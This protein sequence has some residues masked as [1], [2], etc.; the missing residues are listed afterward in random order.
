MSQTIR[1]LGI[2]PALCNTGL[3]IVDYHIATGELKVFRIEIAQTE[4]SADG[5]VV[6]K[7]SDDLSRGRIIVRE[8]QRVIA[9]Y[10]PSLAVAEVP[11]GCQSAR[12][13]FSNGV[14]C[15][16]LASITIPM[17][18]VSPTEVKLAAVGDKNASKAKMIEW[19]VA[20]WPD[21]GWMTKKR[22]G[23]VSLLAANEHMADACAAVAAGILTP[24]F[25]QAVVMMNAMRAA[26][27]A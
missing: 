17:I 23:E 4:K 18:E 27:A 8:I 11:G 2:D 21:A 5:K 16:V 7:S 25:A 3:A 22:L 13:A 1:L 12:G 6:R 19:A 26:G 9:L 15:G 10:K 20:R 14:C 24:Q